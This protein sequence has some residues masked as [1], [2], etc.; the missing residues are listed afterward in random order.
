[1]QPRKTARQ[2]EVNEVGQ[3]AND[4][5]ST[6]GTCR[7]VSTE[8]CPRLHRQI[9]GALSRVV[10]LMERAKDYARRFNAGRVHAIMGSR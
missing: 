4:L 10:G 3:V 7:E 1:M 5:Q 8:E 2:R 9:A 6:P